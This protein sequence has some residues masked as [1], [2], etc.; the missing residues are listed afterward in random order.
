MTDKVKQS[1]RAKEGGSIYSLHQADQGDGPAKRIR[2][3]DEPS[4]VN[5]N[6]SAIFPY[7]ADPIKVL[8]CDNAANIC[9]MPE[10]IAGRF[11]KLHGWTIKELKRP[12][13]IG[14]V[15]HD[16][17]VSLKDIKTINIS[18]HFVFEGYLCQS[19]Q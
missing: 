5:S 3:T 8:M 4:Q 16:G 6:R 14:A 18:S 15:S 11:V 10:D 1:L 7:Y 12:I 19:K 13:H 9:V 17:T 2:A